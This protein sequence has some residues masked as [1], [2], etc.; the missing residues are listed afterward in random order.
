MGNK[1]TL[2]FIASRFPY[3]LEKGDKLRSYNL[4]QGLSEQYSILL[5][6]VSNEPVLEPWKKKLEPLVS[7][8][9]V[10]RLNRALMVM[11]LLMNLFFNAPFQVA[12]STL[13]TTTV[14][15]RL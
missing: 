3:P 7:E 9:H 10:F 4:I 5:I 1:P 11:R 8:M 13:K 2:V 15:L 12:L 14:A 6:I